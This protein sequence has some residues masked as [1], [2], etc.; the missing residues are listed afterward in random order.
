MS[1]RICKN[2]FTL[3]ELVVA[4]AIVAV[5]VSA[6][7]GLMLDSM[8]STTK[9][10]ALERIEEQGSQAMR[11]IRKNIL[12]ADPTTL[13]CPSGPSSSLT[14]NSRTDGNDISLTCADTGIMYSSVA[15]GET[16]QLTS[17]D[18]GVSGGCGEFIR[19]CVNDSNTPVIN[20][21]FS[22][23]LVSGGDRVTSASKTFEST[24]VVRN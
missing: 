1:K 23:Y 13:I 5:V 14:F 12:L 3:I 11:E 22:L 20:V 6:M 17:S 19:S 2:G 4:I 16:I 21:R 7:V 18:V 10:I 15:A 9:T 8:R 24:M